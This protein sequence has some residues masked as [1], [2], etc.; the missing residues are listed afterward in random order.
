MSLPEPKSV[1][2]VAEREV[3]GAAGRHRGIAA[4][5]Q[6]RRGGIDPHAQ[7]AHVAGHEAGQHGLVARQVAPD[8][9]PSQPGGDDPAVGSD[10]RLVAMPCR[11]LNSCETI[12]PLPKLPSGVP[13][14][15]KRA[16]AK[17]ESRK[18][19]KAG[20]GLANGRA[21]YQKLLKELGI[22]EEDIQDMREFVANATNPK[23]Q[24]N[25]SDRRNGRAP[26][27]DRSR[28]LSPARGNCG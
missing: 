21:V 9:R 7:V 14:T 12:P 20:L 16:T 27:P 24:F 19:T 4:E 15:L 3:V 10:A 28:M 26:D 6:G 1:G 8:N 13:S 17:D 18:H 22:T 11:P 2:A 23:R 5:R 25:C